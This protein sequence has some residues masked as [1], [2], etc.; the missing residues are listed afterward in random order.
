MKMLADYILVDPEPRTERK[1]G[2]IILPDNSEAGNKFAR[3][4]VKEVGPG[5]WLHSGKRPDVEVSVGDHV[6]Y[7]KQSAV[8]IDVQERPMHIV[9]ERQ[10]LA[11]LET[12][13]FN[14]QG[15]A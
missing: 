14:E 12:G 2:S 10:I 11:L 7:F 9:Q 5:L 6:L 8:D 4:T 1:S 3:G 15:E 13:D